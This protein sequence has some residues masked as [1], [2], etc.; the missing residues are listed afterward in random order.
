MPEH[1]D[2]TPTTA[3]ALQNVFAALA[4]NQKTAAFVGVIDIGQGNLN[5]VF[6]PL[7][8]PFLYF[9]LGRGAGANLCSFP[10]PEPTLCYAG[11]RM[12]VQSHLDEDHYMAAA[13]PNVQ[14][15]IGAGGAP[16]AR[17]VLPS[18]TMGNFAL[19]VKAGLL[20]N[21]VHV[22]FW[23]LPNA[24]IGNPPLLGVDL[25]GTFV[26]IIKCAGGNQNNSG[27]ALR[28]RNPNPAVGNQDWILLT[29]D[30]HLRTDYFPW[31]D[32]PPPPPPPPPG[33][34]GHM[35]GLVPSHHG[36]RERQGDVPQPPGGLIRPLVYSFGSGNNNGHPFHQ[37][38]HAQG[39][40]VLSYLNQGWVDAGRLQTAGRPLD[41]PNFGPRGN[42]AILWPNAP[43]G[44]GLDSATA[45]DATVAVALVATAAAAAEGA[46][47]G[48][49][50]PRVPGAAAY[51]AALAYQARPNAPVAAYIRQRVAPQAPIVAAATGMGALAAYLAVAIN[52]N[53]AAAAADEASRVEPLARAAVKL[54][55]AAA[56]AAAQQL[57]QQ[58]IAARMAAVGGVATQTNAARQAVFN[59]QAAATPSRVQGAAA[60]RNDRSVV[61]GL[62]FGAPSGI[63]IAAGS[64]LL[65][66]D[67]AHDRVVSLSYGNGALGWIAGVVQTPG[68]ADGVGPAARFRRPT[69]L[70]RNGNDLYVAD[71][72]NHTIRKIDLTTHMV[73]TPAGKAGVVGSANGNG[74]AA[75]FSA[76]A[77][78]A[79]DGT[80]LYVADTGNQTIR[81]IDLAKGNAVATI[82]GQAGVTGNADNMKGDTARFNAPTGL[83]I[84]GKI[85]YVTDTGNHTIRSI[86]L[87]NGNYSVTTI[88]GLAGARGAAGGNGNVARFNE[89]AGLAIVGT[90]LYVADR[91]NHTIRKIALAAG[92][93]VTTIAGLAGVTGDAGVNGNTARF[94]AP[95]G[96]AVSGT[97]LCVA[98]TGNQT[99]RK[100]DIPNAMT[101][102]TAANGVVSELVAENLLSFGRAAAGQ[103]PPTVADVTTL[104]VT[105]SDHA[106]WAY[107]IAAANSPGRPA[108]DPTAGGILRPGMSPV[109]AADAAV[110]QIRAVPIPYV[111]AFQAAL[112]ACGALGPAV[113]LQTTG[114][115][116]PGA[117]PAA[118]RVEY[119]KRLMVA[120]V[121]AMVG[122]RHGVG[123]IQQNVR[124]SVAAARAAVA[125]ARG[126]PIV[127]CHRHPNTCGGALCSSSLH[128]FIT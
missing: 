50:S 123:T 24:R 75:L 83:A 100:I 96:L 105:L 10:D 35:A 71:T 66:A 79:I 121:A 92:H 116:V 76:P 114:V 102:T 69:V 32:L 88:A 40:G 1:K 25:P 51:Q 36:A 101:V 86:D 68:T 108:N 26:E 29:A 125:A 56:E 37:P 47:A 6:N 60:A 27:L 84:S 48:V 122:V 34:D 42:I 80:D 45:N 12:V 128:E 124:A 38:G 81:K 85:L 115:A 78:L 5:A 107:C 20:A 109:A 58:A 87:A 33:P 11:L 23:P 22:Y 21:N 74:N 8:Q 3:A 77:G 65:V 111:E 57:T 117:T 112:A 118:N 30:V 7:G 55:A 4:A 89:P 46:A 13:L 43:L 52:N 70:L 39:D 110:T 19:A 127:G 73:T 120:A 104:A 64:D 72:G 44:P 2:D 62:A 61:P 54:G 90:D 15:G 97:D 49:R 103:P 126:G 106:A 59:Q 53:T 16:S 93:P 31:D 94:N 98:D 9:D 63:A 67:A 119:E 82:A 113:E 91:G 17:F 41:K 18:Q 99:I 14:A 28:I 95:T